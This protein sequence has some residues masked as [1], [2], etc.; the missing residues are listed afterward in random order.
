M[1]M[2]RNE[3]KAAL[4]AGERQLGL[5]VSIPDTA[6]A[7]MLA[8][9]G[10]DWL[11]IDSEHVPL[12]PAQAMRLMQAIAPYPT[13]AIIRPR[14]NDPVE[15]KRMLDCGAQTLLIPYVQSA[16]EAAAAVA[17]VRYP[18][19]G[20]RGVAGMTRASRFGAIDNYVQRAGEE[21]CLL[22][23]AETAEALSQVEAIA[24]T[25]G[26]EGIFIGPADL[27]AS[28]GYPGQPSHP[29]V[30]AAVLEG[31]RRIAAAGL[32]PGI[33]SF[34]Q[35]FLREVAEAGGQFIALGADVALLRQAALTLRRAW[36]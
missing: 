32:P 31:V 23:Q 18:P 7:E 14:W 34:D 5:W 10:Y 33:L 21:I 27:A 36:D 20:I 24:A 8:N 13:S 25:E 11:L 6:S 9:C 22:V 29:N 30:K 28:M 16:E 19:H 15:I 3:F 12:D 17:A 35:P 2:I 4:A 26:V 1:D